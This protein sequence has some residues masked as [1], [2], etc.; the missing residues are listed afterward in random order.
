MSEMRLSSSQRGR[1]REKGGGQEPR[2][3]SESKGQIPSGSSGQKMNAAIGSKHLRAATPVPSCVP[4][5]G[6]AVAFEKISAVASQLVLIFRS[7]V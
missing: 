4:L 5:P 7:F 2:R 1:G 6:P 3:S